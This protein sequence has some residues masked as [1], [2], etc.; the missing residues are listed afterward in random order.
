MMA[1]LTLVLPRLLPLDSTL[2]QLVNEELMLDLA[3]THTTKRQIRALNSTKQQNEMAEAKIAE[4]KQRKYAAK[5]ERKSQ[6]L[7]TRGKENRAI[8][9]KG[10]KLTKKD[11]KKLN[12][13]IKKLKRRLHGECSQVLE[14]Q[15][16]RKHPHAIDVE[17]KG[18]KRRLR[19]Y[20]CIV[21]AQPLTWSL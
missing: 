18:P 3:I 2:R 17:P 9:E 11:P 1:G 4:S 13:I 19:M 10:Q 14:T 21:S 20:T 8:A 7:S 6:K 15:N 12:A 5:A 16:R